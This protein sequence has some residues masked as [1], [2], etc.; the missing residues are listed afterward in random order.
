MAEAVDAGV[1]AA[2]AAGA[3]AGASTVGTAVTVPSAPTTA[4]EKVERA[5]TGA[6]AAEGEKVCRRSNL[7]AVRMLIARSFRHDGRRRSESAI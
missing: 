3:E 2:R 7:F 6:A 5:A 4:A 1:V